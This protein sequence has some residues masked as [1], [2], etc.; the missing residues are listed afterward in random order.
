[1]EVPGQKQLEGGGVR[2]SPPPACLELMGLFTLF[3]MVH[4]NFEAEVQRSYA[5]AALNHKTEREHAR[6]S[7]GL[8]P[9]GY[10]EL[11]TPKY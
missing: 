1:M 6:N 5:H 4:N 7:F 9:Q 3:L 11:K 2:Q 8:L 10:C